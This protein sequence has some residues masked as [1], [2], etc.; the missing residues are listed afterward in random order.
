MRTLL[1]AGLLLSLGGSRALYAAEGAESAPKA[2]ALPKGAVV[3]WLSADCPEGFKRVEG[4]DGRFL[5][6][7]S[8]MQRGGSES[9]SHK[10]E[11]DISHKHSVRTKMDKWQ[12]GWERF[13]ND[14]EGVEGGTKKTVN[15]AS[16]DN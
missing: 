1:V 10:A 3:I 7:G 6:V 12:T 15:V 4:L 13:V 9:H 11:V 14:V 8:P 16:A 5:R 2:A